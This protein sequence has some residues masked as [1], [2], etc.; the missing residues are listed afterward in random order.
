MKWSSIVTKLGLT[1]IILNLIVLI[2]L[3][4]TINQ[5]VSNYYYKEIEENLTELSAKYTSSVHSINDEN[6]LNMFK[7]LALMTNMEIVVFDSFGNVLSSSGI[8][9]Q[10]DLITNQELSLLANGNS[11]SSSYELK[12]GNERFLKVGHPIFSDN[13]FAGGLYLFSSLNVVDE[14]VSDIRQLVILASIGA[15]LLAV[16][17]TFLVSRKMAMPLLEMERVT[18]IIAN[19]SDFSKRIPYSSH[20]EIGSLANGINHLSSKLE[21]YQSNRREFFSNVAHEL[22]TPLTYIS[23]YTNAI[24]KGLFRNDQEKE[25]FLTIIE[26]EVTHM[27]QLVEDLMDLSK[28]EDGQIELNLQEVDVNDVLKHVLNKA[29]IKAKHKELLLDLKVETNTTTI[30]ADRVRLEQIFTNLIENAVRYTDHGKV[31]VK[32][33]CKYN[34][35]IVTI[36]DTGIG[37]DEEN[38]PHLFD[39]FYR[40]DKSRSRAHGGSGLGLAIVNKLVR[41][42]KGTIKIKSEKRV[43]TTCELHFPIDKEI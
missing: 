14:S 35:I 18:R 20:D 30:F 9:R 39:R 34:E 7:S 38:I 23:G 43:G 6:L 2:P 17:F 13:Q 31:I 12:Q 19:K 29:E 21:D 28:I 42:H 5:I 24:R 16:G 3:G 32:V 1:I 37:I 15:I 22:K 4:Y 33:T 26:K 11:V 40:V 8:E 27:N 25:Q 36:S 41:L 10:A